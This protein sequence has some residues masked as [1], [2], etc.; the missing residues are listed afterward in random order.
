MEVAA[1]AGQPDGTTDDVAG[2]TAALAERGDVA[3]PA[4]T[5]ERLLEEFGSKPAF[6]TR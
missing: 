5:A 4:A 6:L 2:I 1:N 3:A